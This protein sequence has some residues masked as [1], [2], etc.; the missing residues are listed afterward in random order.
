MKP[1]PVSEQVVVVTGA[2]SGIGRATALEF[3][4]HGAAVVCAARGADALQTLAAEITAAGGRA[5]AVPTD[6]TDRA[7][8]EALAQRAEHEFARVDT[9]INCVAVSAYGRVEQIPSEDFDRV[10][11]V[12][13]LGQVNG[14]LAALPALRRAGGGVF[15]GVGSVE[16]YRAVPLHAPY[17]ASK[18]AVRAFYDVVRM[19]LAEEGAPIAVSTILPASISTP[20]FEHARNRLAGEPKPPAPIYAPEVVARAIVHAAQH[21]TREIPVGGSA[22]AFLLGQRLSP[23]LTDALFSIGR[24]G[25]GAQVSANPP[26]P[27]D[28]LDEPMPGTGRTAGRHE[29][30]VLRHSAFTALVGERRSVGEMVTGVVSGLRAPV[31]LRRSRH[32]P[33]TRE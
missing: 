16:S 33:A 27:G 6:V 3:G 24:I 29:G 9:W 18:F 13:Y 23:A 15:I 31:M 11:R 17:T 22:V 5:V 7:A 2:S 1:R 28:N 32:Q 19:E 30:A 25:F 4:R 26:T 10:M 12:N 8:V 20:L 21:P 14:T